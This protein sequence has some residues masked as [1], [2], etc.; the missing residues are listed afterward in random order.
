ML[1]VARLERCRCYLTGRAAPRAGRASMPIKMHCASARTCVHSVRQRSI[2]ATRPLARSE[3][4]ARRQGPFA[5]A[6]ELITIAG[7]RKN[8]LAGV[9]AALGYRFQFI[10]LAGWHALNLSMFELASAYRA[11]GMLCYSQLQ[12]REHSHR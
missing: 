5:P 8:E 9:L 3:A 1:R 7:C 10:T 6:P 4:A 2:R 12:Q 11:D